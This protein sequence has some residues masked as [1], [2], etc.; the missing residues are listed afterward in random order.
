MK[1]YILI[2]LFVVYSITFTQTTNFIFTVGPSL[3]NKGLSEIFE[4]RIIKT[5]DTLH[6]IQYAQ[7]ENPT[8]GY[9]INFK[10]GLNLTDN[11]LF[12][13]GF[14]M[15]RFN[16]PEIKFIDKIDN[17]QTGSMNTTIT[18][19]PISTGLYYYLNDDEVSFFVTGGIDYNYAINSL[20][21]IDSKYIL[22][23]TQDATYSML[24]ATL[25]GGIEYNLGKASL[26]VEATYSILNWIG[27]SSN[28]NSKNMFN[29]RAGLKF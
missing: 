20:H 26:I 2:L 4:N 21:N 3:S 23:L 22:K 28:E 8:L 1:F 11:T 7:F 5:N 29:F 16:I 17:I 6:N 9:N 19:Y 15:T 13:G 18:I 10:I 25:G 24:G 12:F 27:K 14:G